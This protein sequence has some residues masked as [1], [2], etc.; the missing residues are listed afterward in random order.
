VLH[1]QG[2]PTSNIKHSSPDDKLIDA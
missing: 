2:W 1:L